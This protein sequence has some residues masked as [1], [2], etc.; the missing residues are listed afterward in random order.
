MTAYLHWFEGIK[1]TKS[2]WKNPHEQI[3]FFY[4][5]AVI[6]DDDFYEAFK[7]KLKQFSCSIASVFFLAS[8]IK[9]FSTSSTYPYLLISKSL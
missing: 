7:V 1:F 6:N 3:V 2:W 8:L 5:E 4:Q 9:V